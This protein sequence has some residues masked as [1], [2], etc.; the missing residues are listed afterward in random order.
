MSADP[1]GGQFVGLPGM[2][3][4]RS[5]LRGAGW[6]VHP[7]HA[8]GRWCLALVLLLAAC[9]DGSRKTTAE[10]PAPAVTVVVVA[11]DEIRPSI[12]F[13]GRVQAQD[14][15]ELRAR[16]EGFLEKRLFNEGQTVKEGD[17]LFVIEQAPYKASIDEIN[18]DIQKAQA[19]LKLANV[20]VERQ[21]T[22]VSRETGTQQRLDVVTAKQGDAQGE[23]A[24][25]K[26]SLEKA[27][28][29]LSYTEIRA[30]LAGR[31]GRATV[32]VGNF[33][34]PST[35]PLA[36]IVRQDPIY[37]TFPVTQREMLD[38]RKERQAD[39]TD[40][41]IYI[42]LADDSRYPH[43]GKIDFVDVTVN[44]GTD[45]VQVRAVFP[46]PDRV[47]VDG[48]LVSVVAEVGKPQASLLIPQQ[49]IQIDQSG[50]FVLVVDSASKVE[51]RRVEV[52]E[53]TGQ[54]L[55]VTKGLHAGEKVI[56]EGVQKVRPGQVVQATEMKKS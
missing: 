17:L 28:L 34:G 15:V 25:Q 49:A 19:A 39:Q 53:A 14:K 5:M 3:W 30:P 54:K 33:V 6:S 52:A 46:N 47:L 48:Q 23:L 56:I 37:V 22:L 32:S 2:S 1:E 21:S 50:P 51:I 10:L 11:Q 29:Q 16:V 9:D 36:T 45:T 42:R 4:T 43:P 41:V 26:A 7:A 55:T 8:R 12:S 44:Q 13:T 40:P 24:R 20:E 31:I 35:G 18:A 27:Q 38:F